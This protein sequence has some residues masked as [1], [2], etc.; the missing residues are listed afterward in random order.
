M[1]TAHL[2]ELGIIMNLSSSGKTHVGMK[3]S[4]N[5][6]CL[7]IYRDEGLFVVADGM[8]GHASGEVASEM[9]AETIAAFYRATSLDEDITWPY[10]YN[11]TQTYQEN[12]IR[13]G[14]EMSNQRIFQ[15][16]VYDMKLKGM[17]T[18]MV[19][20]SF[21][22]SKCS[23]G[24]V[25]D[26]RVYRMRNSV[27]DQ[28]TEDHSLLNDYMKLRPGGMTEEEIENFPH[29]NVIVRALGMKDNVEV[30]VITEDVMVGDL[31]LLCSDGLSGMI[32]DQEMSEIINRV[33]R[34]AES[35]LS[36][37]LDH[38]CDTLIEAANRNGGND[39]ITVLLVRCEP[40]YDDQ[41][42]HGLDT[43]KLEK[44]NPFAPAWLNEEPV[45]AVAASDAANE[46]TAD[47]STADESTADE[48][49][50]MVAE[51]MAVETE[52]NSVSEAA[53]LPAEA[54]VAEVQA[55]SSSEIETVIMKPAPV[56]VDQSVETSQ[57][58]AV[59]NSPEITATVE[60]P[61]DAPLDSLKTEQV[62][63]NLS[64]SLADTAEA[65][66]VE[67]SDLNEASLQEIGKNVKSTAEQLIE[68]KTPLSDSSFTDIQ[69][70]QPAQSLDQG[71]SESME[72]DLDL[73]GPK[74][75]VAKPSIQ[76]SELV[77]E[78]EESSFDTVRVMPNQPRG[79]ERVSAQSQETD[80]IRLGS[81]ELGLPMLQP[82]EPEEANVQAESV[83]DLQTMRV[84]PTLTESDEA[85]PPKVDF[86]TLQTVADEDEVADGPVQTEVMSLGGDKESVGQ[87]EEANESVTHETETQLSPLTAV[88][89][90]SAVEVIQ[91]VSENSDDRGETKVED[92]DDHS[93]E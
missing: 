19:A 59:E 13:V 85:E 73:L 10:K 4:H 3:R 55:V 83:D 20:M 11:Y 88:E 91:D 30:D 38:L 86:D 72:D 40:N 68:D 21:Y 80:T 49:I 57:I 53:D 76:M 39:N 54:A 48:M 27:L 6:D 82:I 58:D 71:L 9:S 89:V 5:E 79:F 66:A 44:V 63:E 87:S 25:G 35:M 15:S 93:G 37:D 32:T 41:N 42:D 45:S 56:K 22:D 62:S 60:T 81:T 64:A 61:L 33:E 51:A 31:L 69:D 18:T 8:G 43:P 1:C 17:G 12:R 23:I 74:T 46:S 65:K 90:V 26:S 16:S 14:V 28:L 77:S 36:V 29:K 7:R 67:E 34:D 75:I 78:T 84:M 70:D 52:T 50:A 92:S 47:E 2:G 24:H